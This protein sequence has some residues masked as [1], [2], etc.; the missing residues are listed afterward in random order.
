MQDQIVKSK[1]E[2]AAKAA[3]A[4]QWVSGAR[5]AI[6]MEK[7]QR[8]A[9]DTLIARLEVL[10]K[11]STLW[12][13]NQFSG[14]RALYSELKS[15]QG[16]LSKTAAEA[17]RTGKA[18]DAGK[19]KSYA[20]AV[21]RA[22]SSQKRWGEDMQRV[23]GRLTFFEQQMDAVLRASYRFKAAGA[24]LERF[25]RGIFNGFKSV[26]QTFGDFDFAIRRAAGSIGFF[27]EA[28]KKGFLGRGENGIENR[29][30]ALSTAALNVARDL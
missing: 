16:G 7:Q 24:D 14:F 29:L 28:A 19:I 5:D 6:S 1:Q 27:D 10:R 26:M 23:S 17:V 12:N 20:S 21:D 25:A 8:A 15:L 30:S 11:N 13:S 22:D 9:L 4:K 18:L 3:A 2:A